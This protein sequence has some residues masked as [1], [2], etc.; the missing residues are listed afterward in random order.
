MAHLHIK[1]SPSSQVCPLFALHIQMEAGV[2]STSILQC[3]ISA[4]RH[5]RVSHPQPGTSPGVKKGNNVGGQ[6]HMWD[7][8]SSLFVYPHNAAKRALLTQASNKAGS[9]QH[10]D[11]GGHPR[12]QGRAATSP[13][14]STIKSTFRLEES[15]LLPSGRCYRSSIRT[16]RL[17]DSSFGE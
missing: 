16:N 12:L 5:P 1:T 11:Q 8:D 3:K 13:Q 10:E 15:H 6:H 14:P 7:S 4:E 17:R 9:Q 2:L